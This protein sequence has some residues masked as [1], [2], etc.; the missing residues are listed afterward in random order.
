MKKLIHESILGSIVCCG[1]PLLIQT[2]L[3]GSPQWENAVGC[4]THSGQALGA[5]NQPGGDAKQNFI[6]HPA[7]ALWHT[8]K[9]KYVLKKTFIQTKYLLVLNKWLFGCCVSS[10]GTHE[11]FSSVELTPPI[12][13]PRVQLCQPLIRQSAGKQRALQDRR[14]PD[15]CLE[16]LV[17]GLH[18]CRNS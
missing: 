14:R 11:R 7:S 8:R 9:K 10:F 5:K 13:C 1:F 6:T 16:N 15:G 18:V 2:Y 3:T 4:W 17:Y 12:S